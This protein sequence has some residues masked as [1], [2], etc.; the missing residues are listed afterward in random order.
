LQAEKQ[1]LGSAADIKKE[2]DVARTQR[3]RS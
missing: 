3:D 2:L 1:K